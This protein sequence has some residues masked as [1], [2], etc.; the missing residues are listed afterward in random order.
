MSARS[1]SALLQRADLDGLV[2]EVDRSCARGDHER[3]LHIRDSCRRLTADLGKQLW[4]PAQ[5]AEYRLALEA[6]APLAASVVTP[7]AARFAL[8]PLTEVV[9]QHHGFG[10][11]AD[12]LDGAVLPHVAQE[13]ILRGEDLRDDP[14]AALTDVGLPGALEPWEPRYPLPTYR[15]DECLESGAPPPRAEGSPVTAPPGPPA[16]AP[17]LLSS[18]LELTGVWREQSTG[19][20]HVAAVRGDAEAAVA[21]LVPGHARMVELRLPEAMAR[22]AWAGASGGARGRRPGGAAGRAGAWWVAHAASGLDFPAEPDELEHQLEELGWYAIE[23]DERDLGW[24]LRLAIEGE[25]WAVA[26]DAHDRQPPD[27]DPLA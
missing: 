11:L 2:R 6:P 4:G 21:A 24:S 26:V 10:E 19:D 5:Y 9:S 12:H 23:G 18:L 13:R 7:G 25:G 14:R 8:G 27:D 20:T 16:D 22:M 3:V 17:R 15:A 1:L